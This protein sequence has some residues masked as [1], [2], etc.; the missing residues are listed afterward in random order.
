MKKM[1]FILIFSVILLPI[2]FPQGQ[3]ALIKSFQTDSEELVV[4]MVGRVLVNEWEEDYIRVVS[5]IEINN[6]SEQILMRLL[7]V[8]R[9]SIT[10]EMVDGALVIKMPR[11]AHQVSINGEV[12]K[13]VLEYQIFV[14][15]GT[16]VNVL[17]AHNYI[18]F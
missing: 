2:A 5:N 15:R 1:L 11:I 12:L 16:K 18:N 8:G 4:D 6:F 13:E 17:R 7:M 9:Y 14:P 3:K 10:S